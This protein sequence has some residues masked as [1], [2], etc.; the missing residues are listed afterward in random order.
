MKRWTC[1]LAAVALLV[2]A[3]SVQAQDRPRTLD[4]RDIYAAAQ[5]NDPVFAAARAARAAAG[6]RVPQA[7]AL[8]LPSLSA[9][10]N[11]TYN[12]ADIQYDSPTSIGGI[13]ITSATRRYNSNGYGLSLNQPVFRAQNF[14]TY[15]QAQLQVDQ[16]DLQLRAASQDLIL[17]VAQAYF[18]VLLAENNVALVEA[19][20]Q[21]ITQQ[22]E[23]AKRGFELG[24]VTITD[25]NEAQ[26]RLDLVISQEIAARNDLEIRRQALMLLTGQP[27]QPLAPLRPGIEPQPPVP[28]DMQAWVQR[29]EEQ[30]FQLGI[31]ARTAGIADAEVTRN[32]AGHLPT[33]DIVGSYS[34]TS[35]GASTLTGVGSD[36]QATSI[37]LQ[38]ELPLFQ[39]GAQVSRVREALAN[40]SRAQQDLEQ[41]RRQTTLSARQ[42]F[43]GVANG[44]AQV[45]ALEQ[46]LVSSEVS[47]KSNQVGF[48]VGVRTSVDVL[49]AQQ[50]L[51]NARRDLAQAWHSYLLSRLRL[52]ANAGSL[53]EQHLDE[54]NAL[55]AR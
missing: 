38:M 36:T 55:L 42:S 18:D 33:F 46:A 8:F 15:R 17:R 32:R 14:P 16:A 51:F 11:T 3:A 44:V 1:I 2:T 13:P 52:H 26:A 29:A 5:Q 49:N 27:P 47:L 31:Q 12:D 34:D 9:N 43:L 20:K 54:I 37:S 39:G 6:E 40:R 50:Q 45:R 28:N 7:R 10:A 48:E 35:A 53:S 4:L 23:Q 30:N 19:Q 22:W 41:A 24:T 25:T 21:A